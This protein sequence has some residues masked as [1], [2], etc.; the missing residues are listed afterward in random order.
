MKLNTSNSTVRPTSFLRK[1]MKNYRQTNNKEA[2]ATGTVN[3]ASDENTE[4]SYGGAD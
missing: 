2:E 1:V 3:R 4:P